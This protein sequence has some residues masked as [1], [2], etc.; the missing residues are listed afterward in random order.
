MQTGDLRN[1]CQPQ[2][3]A[4]DEL[5]AATDEPFEESR[6][7]VLWNARPVIDY[8]QRYKPLATMLNAHDDFAA[9]SCAIALRVIDEVLNSLCQQRS[10]GMHQ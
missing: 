1:D 9:W 6:F 5:P 8:R 3:A 10:V 7:I 4:Y 2:P